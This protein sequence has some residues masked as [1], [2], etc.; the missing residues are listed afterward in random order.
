[1][2]KYHKNLLYLIFGLVT[3]LIMVFKLVE[4]PELFM[5]LITFTGLA[6]LLEG[7]IYSINLLNRYRKPENRSKKFRDF[8]RESD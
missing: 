6:V 3:V 8:V 5:I 7:S 2:D 1:M 4:L